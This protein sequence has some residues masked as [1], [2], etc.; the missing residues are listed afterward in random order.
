MPSMLFILLVQLLNHLFHDLGVSLFSFRSEKVNVCFIDVGQ[1]V[2]RKPEVCLNRLE[3]DLFVSRH[4]RGVDPSLIFSL[5]NI[6][7]RDTS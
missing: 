7:S 3:K 6:H 2:L 1:I 5:R 4:W